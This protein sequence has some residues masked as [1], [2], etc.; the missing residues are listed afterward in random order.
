M[1]RIIVFLTTFILFSVYCKSQTDS[2]AITGNYIGHSV[3]DLVVITI[4]VKENHNYILKSYDL[5]KKLQ[6]KT[7]GK[8]TLEG[9]KLILIE[10]SGSIIV[11]EKHQ[12]IRFIA[13]KSGHLC[14]AK[15]YHNKDQNEF[16]AELIRA[17][18]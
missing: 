13:D 11:L 14:I 12:N 6:K 3:T 4:E 5:N 2:F 16:W 15:F 17:G 10:K 1:N 7:K 9:D 8:W 18:C